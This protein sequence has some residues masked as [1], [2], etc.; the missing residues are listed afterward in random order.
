VNQT[1]CAYEHACEVLHEAIE[2][3]AERAKRG[4]EVP[5]P[6][7]MAIERIQTGGEK[8]L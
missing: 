6:V 7:A 5:S 1:G 8:T 2:D 3:L 4:E